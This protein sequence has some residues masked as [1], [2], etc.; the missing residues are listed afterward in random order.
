MNELEAYVYDMRNKPSERNGNF[1]V[2]ALV[3][4]LYEVGEEETKGVYRIKLEELKKQGDPI[5][6]RYMEYQMRDRS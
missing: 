5:D 3:D 1:S 6:E 4:W 2:Q